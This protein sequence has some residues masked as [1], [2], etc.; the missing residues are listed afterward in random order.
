MKSL[1]RVCV[2]VCEGVLVKEIR[3]CS[4][5]RDPESPLSMGPERPCYATDLNTCTAALYM[6]SREEWRCFDIQQH[7]S[8]VS[9]LSDEICRILSYFHNENTIGCK[10]TGISTHTRNFWNTE[11]WKSFN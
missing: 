1:S 7:I 8:L 5:G 6:Y 2:C 11:R 10:V 4:M 9:P 3:L